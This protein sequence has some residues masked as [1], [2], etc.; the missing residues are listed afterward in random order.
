MMTPVARLVLVRVTPR[1]QLVDA[2]AWLIDPRPRRPHRRAA[3]RRLHHHL[4]QLALDLPD[5]RADR[6]R[7][8]AAG[9]QVPARLAAQRAAAAWTSPA[10]SS[11]ALLCRLGV[12]HLGADAPGPA[13][14]F[15]CGSTLVGG[16]V[17]AWRYFWHFRR[18]EYPLLDL[19]LFRLPLFRADDD[20]RHVLPARHRRD[21]VPVSAD[22]A[23]RLRPH[24]VRERH[25]SPSPPRSAPSR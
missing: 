17:A 8:R 16:D 13:R 24:A 4:C 20:R 21:A 9:Q 14:R 7:R 11:P 19:R 6:H 2:M 10:S 25:R 18:T 1:N 15:G 3:D 5:Q 23:A 22:A 12:R